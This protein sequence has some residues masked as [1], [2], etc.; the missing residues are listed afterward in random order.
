MDYITNVK[1]TIKYDMLSNTFPQTNDPST[2][3]IEN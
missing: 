3:S 2:R 1:S